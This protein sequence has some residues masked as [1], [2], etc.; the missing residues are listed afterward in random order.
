MVE[1]GERYPALSGGSSRRVYAHDRV[2]R[3]LWR[4]YQAGKLSDDEL[5]STLDRLDLERVEQRRCEHCHL[6]GTPVLQA[7]QLVADLP[8]V[9]IWRHSK[10]QHVLMWRGSGGAI[11]PSEPRQ[12]VQALISI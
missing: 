5:A 8:S 9:Q 7:E 1:T 12:R 6:L 10:C 4:A 2:R 3:E 11:M